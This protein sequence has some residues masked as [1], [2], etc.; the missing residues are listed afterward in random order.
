M[1][2][3]DC[4]QPQ[5]LQGALLT[6]P[7]MLMG[8]LR[9]LVSRSGRMFQVCVCGVSFV[10]VQVVGVCPSSMGTYMFMVRL[11]GCADVGSGGMLDSHAQATL[12]HRSQ[13][14]F[15]A[16]L[17]TLGCAHKQECEHPICPCLWRACDS[18]SVAAW[19]SLNAC[20]G[21]R[22]KRCLAARHSYVCHNV[23]ACVPDWHAA[24]H[25]LWLP[26]DIAKASRTVSQ[27]FVCCMPSLFQ[28]CYGCLHVCISRF[29]LHP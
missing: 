14:C 10:V 27:L 21:R 6:L 23:T 28:H 12:Q 13:E 22:W 17:Q 8:Q 25:W 4:C 15:M 5:R 19:V 9:P 29:P 24:A 26:F 18:V 3:L 2:M 7:G 11:P 1:G 16:T 20:S